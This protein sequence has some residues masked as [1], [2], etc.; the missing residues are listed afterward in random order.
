MA[1]P[2]ICNLHML[3]VHIIELV[4]GDP[5][6]GPPRA[7]WLPCNAQSG[8][9]SLSTLTGASN[10]LSKNSGRAGP[11]KQENLKRSPHWLTKSSCC[12][13]PEQNIYTLSFA[14]V[15]VSNYCPAGAYNSLCNLSSSRFFK[16]SS[17]ILAWLWVNSDKLVG[18]KISFG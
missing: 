9:L 4:M 6:M 10:N 5:A 18:N 16:F 2:A 14:L 15:A 17:I 12:L 1:T 7:N 8:H 11:N 13:P 3:Q